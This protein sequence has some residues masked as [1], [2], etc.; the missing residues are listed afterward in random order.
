MRMERDRAKGAFLPFFF[1]ILLASACEREEASMEMKAVSEGGGLTASQASEEKTDIGTLPEPSSDLERSAQEAGLIPLKQV[2]EG[3]QVELKYSTT[4]NFVGKDLYGRFNT[5]YVLPEVAKKLQLAQLVLQGRYPS[6]RFIVYDGVRPLRVQ[7][8]MWNSLDISREEKRKFLASPDHRSMHNYG[9]AIDLSI[10]DRNGEPLD[11]GTP[12]DHR[13]EKAYPR[14]EDELLEKG[15]LTQKQVEN[16]KLLRDVMK[17]AGFNSIPTE[18]WHFS[19][20]DKQEMA[21]HYEVVE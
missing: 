19:I 9:A 11:M 8:K 3:V 2:V 6:Y 21:R 16:R 12:F 5:C 15:V 14:K 18:W 7:R 4:D 1:F 10:V 17:K 13:G 20:K